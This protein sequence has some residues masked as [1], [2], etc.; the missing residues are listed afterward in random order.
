MNTPTR[1]PIRQLEVNAVKLVLLISGAELQN[2]HV[3]GTQFLTQ[4]IHDTG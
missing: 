2:L 1:F 3:A 4:N